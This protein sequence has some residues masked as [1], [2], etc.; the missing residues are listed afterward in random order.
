VIKLVKLQYN[1]RG[2][3]KMVMVPLT[4]PQCE[5]EIVVKN[6]FY[7][8][9]KQRYMCNNKKCPRKIFMVSYTNKAYDPKIRKQIFEQT[10]N[11]SG[12]R[13]IARNLGISKDTVTAVLKKTKN[14]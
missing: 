4:C 13:A 10:V 3:T 14:L 5:S 9:G 8:N 1:N 2:G 11:G 6:G 12:T 7:P